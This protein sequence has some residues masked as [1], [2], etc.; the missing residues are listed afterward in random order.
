MRLVLGAFT[1]S[2]VEN[3]Y[4]E[5]NEPPLKLRFQKLGLQYNSKLK[6]LASNPAYDCTLNPKQQNLFEQREKTIKT[7]G[8][9]MKHIMEDRD[10]ANN[11]I[12]LNSPPWLLK[13]TVVIPYLNNLPKN[14]THP[15]TNQEKLNIQERYPNHLHIMTDGSKSNNGTGCGAVLH[16]KTLEK[17]LPKE[18]SIFSVETYAI[19]L[20]LK[21]VSTSN[22]EKF[23]IHSDA[24]SALQ[25]LKKTKPDNPFI[26]KLLNKLN[27]MNH[28]KKVIFCWI[29]SHI[30]IQGNDKADSFAKAALNMVSDKKKYHILTS[31]RK[32][33]K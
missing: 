17:R 31:N 33:G 2:S 10:F 28:S 3:L 21:L 18:A 22:K 13:Q 27:S 26:V 7:F 8:L 16:K 19:N 29:P 20:A 9:C 12:Q 4:S 30:G 5:A 1:T 32:S 11:T 15:L 25:S 23:F 6:S 14:K 24:I